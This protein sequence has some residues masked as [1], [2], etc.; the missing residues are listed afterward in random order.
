MTDQV[1]TT[2]GADA[3]FDGAV[4]AFDFD[5]IDA[6]RVDQNY[7]EL[8]AAKKSLTL[9]PVRKPGPQVWFR[10]HPELKFVTTLFKSET[11]R[12]WYLVTPTARP[13]LE[14]EARAWAI[15]T[16]ITT[17]GSVFLW[18]VQLPDAEGK[19]NAWHDSAHEAARQ[20]MQ[21]WTRIRAS[22]DLGGYQAFTPTGRL[23]EPAW[24]EVTMT[25]LMRLAF[26]Q[27]VIDKY[28]HPILKQL[29]GEAP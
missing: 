16:G 19:L 14:E 27:R 18:P 25:E 5:N 15:Y 28:D 29:R 8:G 21:V 6:L 2:N 13:F 23:D 22:R 20:A 17:H 9:V 10:I 11:E 26:K 3:G 1:P 7:A 24:P 12:E 4:D